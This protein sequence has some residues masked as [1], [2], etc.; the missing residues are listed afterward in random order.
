MICGDRFFLLAPVL[1]QKKKKINYL[2]K[3][4]Q[5]CDCS[6]AKAGSVFAPKGVVS[7]HTAT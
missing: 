5:V 6:T 7:Q 2:T 1:N 4:L 3:S